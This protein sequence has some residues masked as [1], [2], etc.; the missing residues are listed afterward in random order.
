MT[1]TGRS[2]DGTV[3]GRPGLSTVPC[4]AAERPWP[5]AARAS[6]PGGRGKGPG[7]RGSGRNGR[8]GQG[9]GRPARVRGA[10]RAG[11]ARPAARPRGADGRAYR[12]G[13][14]DAPEDE[15]AAARRSRRATLRRTPHRRRR[16]LPALPDRRRARPRGRRRRGLRAPRHDVPARRAAEHGEQ[17]AQRDD[18][19]LDLPGVRAELEAVRPQP[20]PAERLRTGQGGDPHAG[21]RKPHH[22]LVRRPVG[23]GRPGHRRQP[24]AQPHPAER[25]APGLGLLPLHARRRQPPGGPAR[26]AVRVVPAADHGHAPGPGGRGGAGRRGRARPG[27]LAHHPGAAA[28]VERGE[29][30]GQGRVPGAALVAAAGGRG[31]GGIG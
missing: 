6:G 19:R 1:A 31:R 20:A 11:T 7:T 8:A 9:L 29:G 28:V 10:G 23:A 2:A 25:A 3:P 12:A 27:A 4:V 26:G 30:V 16:P 15:R 22:R 17:E 13:A 24:G 5:R 14:G 18:R 21:R